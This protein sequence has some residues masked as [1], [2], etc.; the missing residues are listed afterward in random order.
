MASIARGLDIL[1]LLLRQIHAIISGH[2]IL[3]AYESRYFKSR[4]FWILRLIHDVILKVEWTKF[5]WVRLCNLS[6]NIQYIP[7]Y[8]QCWKL[9][10][11]FTGLTYTLLLS[12][13]VIS[14][15]Y[16]SFIRN[17]TTYCLAQWISKLPG[18]FE[19]HWVR[20]YLVNFMGLEG[21]VNATVYKTGLIFTGLGHGKLS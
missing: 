20:Q 12:V 5:D 9:G 2:S 18:S 1:F 4:T 16:M 17:K 15:I 13:T 21:I 10:K 14:N 11:I 6:S 8:L 7:S 19:I 3:P